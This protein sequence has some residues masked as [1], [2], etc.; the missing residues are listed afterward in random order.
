MGGYGV[1]PSHSQTSL[2][3]GVLCIDLVA[4]AG[5]CCVVDTCRRRWCLTGGSIVS[6]ES[7]VES[8]LHMASHTD[9]LVKGSHSHAYVGYGQTKKSMFERLVFTNVRRVVVEMASSRGCFFFSCR[10]L[11]L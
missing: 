11:V 2:L 1:F 7:Q 5:R 9:S 10:P 6:L 3:R 4:Y 8:L